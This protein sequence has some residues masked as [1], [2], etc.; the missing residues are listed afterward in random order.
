MKYTFVI[1]LFFALNSNAQVKD[2]SVFEKVD[3]VSTKTFKNYGCININIP[4]LNGSI[5]DVLNRYSALFV[6]NYSPGML[7][8][9]SVRGLGAH[10]TAILWNGI[11]LQSNMNSSIDLNLIPSFFVDNASLETGANV[12]AS[13]SGAL[14]GAIHLN[15]Q[16]SNKNYSF[17]EFQY[18][19]FNS[20]NMGLGTNFNVKNI[21]FN[22]KFYLKSSQNNFEYKNIFLPNQPLE[23]LSHAQLLQSG[24]MQSLNWKL[25]NK[26]QVY[27]NYWYM[28]TH[29]QLPSPLGVVSIDDE[30]QDDY[31]NKVLL[32]H[33]FIPKSNIKWVNQIAFIDETINYFNLK[34][35]PSYNH[36]N[37]YI[38]SSDLTWNINKQFQFISDVNFNRQ[39]AGADGYKLGHLRHL[40]NLYSGFKWTDKKEKLLLKMGNRQLMSDGVMMPSAPDFA[41]EFSVNNHLKFKSNLAASYRMP[42]FNDLYWNPGGNSDLKP[43]MGKKAELS[44]LFI[45]KGIKLS[46]TGFY[47]LV[48]NWILWSPNPVNNIWSAKNAKKVESRGL[49]LSFDASKNLFKWHKITVLGSYQFVKSINKATYLKDSNILNKQLFYTPNHTG[50]LNIQYS[51]KKTSLT[52]SS[53]YVGTC[54]TTFDNDPNYTLPAYLLFN[55]SISNVFHLKNHNFTAV[56]QVNN[57]RNSAYQVVE[58]RPMPLRS[59]TVTLK[60]NINHE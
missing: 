46:L 54:F 18:G 14:A 29:R 43:E 41:A 44:T 15:N 51:Y 55:A 47:H 42:S 2:T 40:I 19:S 11:N 49:E 21:S 4:E 3:F 13:G 23:K 52:L 22:T 59:Y 24:F 6:K 34:L 37:S 56:F 33:S 26:N 45:Q 12:A 53:R 1:A 32:K 27:F 28:E 60:F 8:S 16:I 25:N 57:L 20:K 17:G 38:M 31:S 9:T 5:A 10:H 50:F 39:S 58:N 30:N 48:D 36:S 7:A 35:S